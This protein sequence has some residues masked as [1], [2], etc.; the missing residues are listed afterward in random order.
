[1]NI[2]LLCTSGGRGGLELY[3]QR[4][5]HFITTKSHNNC[6]LAVQKNGHIAESATVGEGETQT[7]Y[8]QWSFRALPVISA[9]KLA[10]YIDAN[11]IDIVHMHW[12]KDLSLAALAKSLSSRKPKLVYTRHMGI[13]RSKKDL[14]HRLLYGQVDQLLTISQQMR[15]EALEFL[16]LE[17]D[18][19]KLLYLGVPPAKEQKGSDRCVRL[20]G[21]GERRAFHIGMFGRI[22]HGKGQH[23]LIE[24]MAILVARKLDVSATVIGHVMD[25]NYFS[26]LQQILV[27]RGLSE[28]I[29]FVGF[30]D[31]PMAVMPSFDVVTLLTYCETF[32]L[33]LVEA[34]RTGVAVIGTDAGGV[35]EIICDEETGLL[36]PPGDSAALAESLQRLYEDKAQKE[37]LAH[38][39]KKW[40]DSVFDEEKNFNALMAIFNNL[41]EESQ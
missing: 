23:L 17:P 16:P 22:E 25:E 19:I 20:P 24:A 12:G 3:T 7:L 39:G 35:P 6:Y 21:R 4:E 13:T 34:M 2:L 5:A 29:E 8:L 37:Q 40:A 33:V 18:Q 11:S 28:R 15:K 9:V 10:R 41:N 30:I 26:Q 27:E 14:Y 38:R 36:V 31:D 32:G 1:M